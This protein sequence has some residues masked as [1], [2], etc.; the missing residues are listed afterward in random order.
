MARAKRRRP[1]IESR[2]SSGAGPDR[3]RRRPLDEWAPVVLIAVVALGVYAN[4]VGNE[5]LY[6][7]DLVI[8]D[9]P[10]TSDPG[11]W[12]EIFT[13]GYWYRRSTDPIYRPVALLTYLANHAITGSWP[14]GYRAVNL[15]LHAGV[16]LM[17]Y[18][19]GLQLFRR[20]WP[21]VAAALLFAVHPIHG[22]AVVIVVGRADLLC[23]LLYLLAVWL[24]LREP[25]AFP[26]PFSPRFAG[27]LV[28][29][30]LALLTKENAVTFIGAAVLVDL[31]R[32]WQGDGH[33][34]IRPWRAFLLDRLARRYLPM[35]GLT[36]L[37]LLVRY[38][39]LGQL[40]RPRGIGGGGIENPLDS[41][42]VVGRLL[43]PFVLLGK[44]LNLLVWPHPLCYDYS[45]NAI[46]VATGLADHRVLI[47][48]AWAA[49]FVIL[50]VVS[51]RRERRMLWCLGFFAITYLIV[52]N[53]LVLIGTLFAERVIYLPSVAWCWCVGLALTAL[54]DRCASI[55][56]GGRVL[57]IIAV[58]TAVVGVSAYAAETVVRNARVFCDNEALYADG[59]RVNPGSARCQSF[60][61]R[62]YIG[63]GDHKTAIKYLRAALDIDDTAWYDHML[64][65]QEYALDGQID[66]GIECL[67]R[68]YDMSTGHYRFDPAFLLG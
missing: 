4:S 2:T 19:I 26:S 42:E 45:Y 17:V 59:V 47:G 39:A 13:H 64:I 25:M 31:W 14:A 11:R 30:A 68:A 28:L 10:R 3:T 60:A 58:A 53:S 49:V 46:P 12:R 21:A 35:V 29:L 24:L 33:P 41:A 8:L 52:S 56:T 61:A 27:V 5:F 20:R 55:G 66:R 40:M 63:Q 67:R 44:Y 50:A 16:S 57:G 9:D 32:R 48:L 18:A 15:A 65:G 6:D 37:S 7:D 23:A 62:R 36:A 43:T 22:E 34:Q 38:Q 1:R 54:V 51:W